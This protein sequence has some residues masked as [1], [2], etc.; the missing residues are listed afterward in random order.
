MPSPNNS[1]VMEE[2]TSS[3]FKITHETPSENEKLVRTITSKGI[4]I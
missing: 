4:Q 3:V 2:T 1:V